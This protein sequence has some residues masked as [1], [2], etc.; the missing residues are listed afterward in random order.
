M[1]KKTHIFIE[2][3]FDKV[4]QAMS[5]ELITSTSQGTPQVVTALSSSL[6]GQLVVNKRGRPLVD[7]RFKDKAREQ[8]V[9]AFQ[10]HMGDSGSH[11]ID[12]INRGGQEVHGW[13]DAGN[14]AETLSF[15]R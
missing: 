15:M 4:H 3:R 5:F 7:P 8:R 12:Y 2:A 9:E 1:P 11:I 6:P 10:S 14:C 13:Y